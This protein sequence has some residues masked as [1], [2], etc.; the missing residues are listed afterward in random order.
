LN[1]K[2]RH[3]TSYVGLT[4]VNAGVRHEIVKQERLQD[5]AALRSGGDDLAN[6]PLAIAHVVHLASLPLARPARGL[7]A[8]PFA[9]VLIEVC[10]G[11]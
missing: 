10:Q 3:L 2:P 9:R 1:G 5:A 8:I 11:F 7:Q 6:H 4:T